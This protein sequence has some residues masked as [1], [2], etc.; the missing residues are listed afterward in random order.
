MTDSGRTRKIA[1]FDFDGTLS[2]KDTLVPFVA[3]VAGY[4]KAVAAAIS[5]GF[6][7]IKGDISPTDRDQL[8]E[9][10]VE[11]LLAGR[12][13]RELERAGGE[14]ATK[15]LDSGLNPVLVDQLKRHVAAGHETLMV[16]ASLGYYL[17]PIARYFN[18]SEVI[19]VEPDSVDG[20]LTGS[21]PPN[22]RA[23]EKRRLV[24][25][26]LGLGEDESLEGIE[27]WAYGNSS[28]DHE[29]LEMADHA[30]W[31]GKESKRPTGSTQISPLPTF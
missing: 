11:R 24:K 18:V 10:M 27:M 13:L 8:K 17:R 28:G 1:A 7:G 22:V 19:A 26:W 25:A 16:S 20:V 21:M 23:A 30:F 2:N 4:P 29:L 6:A 31:A 14:H 3:G 9:F 15:L 12:T 5:A